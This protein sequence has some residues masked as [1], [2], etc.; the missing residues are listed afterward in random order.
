MQ[1]LIFEAKRGRIGKQLAT[2]EADDI[3]QA[4]RTAALNWGTD[5]F[6]QSRASWLIAQTEPRPLTGPIPDDPPAY[7]APGSRKAIIK[8]PTTKAKAKPVPT[9]LGAKQ[10]TAKAK[11]AERLRKYYLR[12]LGEA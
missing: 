3:R 12:K 4:T 10:Y 5:I 7:R 1:W 11:K 2:I 6:I 9:K 8:R